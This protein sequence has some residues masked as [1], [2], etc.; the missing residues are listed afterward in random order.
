ML[1]II[2]LD[3][4]AQMLKVHPST[5]YRM[6]KK[7]Q[8]PCFKIGSDWRFNVESIERWLGD[9]EAVGEANHRPT[10]E[11]GPSADAD[12][13]ISLDFPSAITRPRRRRKKAVA[14]HVQPLVA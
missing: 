10:E 14:S 3:Q 11:D 9:R 12:G 5:I 6:V 8:I 4:V 2:T 7:G 13:S 1:N